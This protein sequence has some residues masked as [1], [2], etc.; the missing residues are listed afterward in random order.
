MHQ[1]NPVMSTV[2]P[3]VANAAIAANTAIPWVNPNEPMYRHIFRHLRIEIERGRFKAGDKLPSVRT[4]VTDFKVSH[5]TVLRAL[6]ELASIGYVKLV[7]GSGSY[8]TRRATEGQILPL[9][10]GIQQMFKNDSANSPDV[11][12]VDDNHLVRHSEPSKTGDVSSKNPYKN[13]TSTDK[14]TGSSDSNLPK[15]SWQRS[16]RTALLECSTAEDASI[17]PAGLA[18]LRSSIASYVRRSRGICAD[19][20]QVVVTSGVS[21]AIALVSTLCKLSEQTVG[22]EN[23]GSPKIRRLL[24]AH[25]AVLKPIEL[26]NQGMSVEALK[27]LECKIRLLHVTPNH[28]PTGLVMSERRRQSLL[29]WVSSQQAVILEDDFGGEF[30]L[31]MNRET[32][33]FALG[34]NNVVYLGGFWGS[35]YPLVHTAFLVLP[36]SLTET[37]IKSSI[38]RDNEHNLLEQHALRHM[39]NDGHLELHL[40]RQ[41]KVIMEKR[42]CA[43]AALK[44]TLGAR[45]DFIGTSINGK[46][47]IRFH[48]DVEARKVITAALRSGL[49]LTSTTDF[50]ISNHRPNDFLLSYDG[51]ESKQIFNTALHFAGLLGW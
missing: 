30:A 19:P 44:Q 50:F 48:E 11:Q 42:A 23:P 45:I 28:N 43:I 14:E 3:L 8:V 46:Q 51:M 20:A 41:K 1:L 39:L 22:V 13:S 5:P 4:M 47:L 17:T 49:P 38:L 24:T 6:E 36:P 26:D 37:A 18:M 31:S 21:S 2:G 33:L 29:N 25:G 40:K 15:G 35:L 10:D 9:R 27:E 7:Q 34:Q 16:V 32:S 12:V